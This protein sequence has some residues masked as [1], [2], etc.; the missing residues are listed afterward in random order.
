MTVVICSCPVENKRVFEY[1]DYFWA[2]FISKLEVQL[3]HANV[4]P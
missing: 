2:F 1:S 3:V 4:M